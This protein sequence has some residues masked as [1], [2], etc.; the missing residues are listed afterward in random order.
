MENLIS[1][2]EG[3]W[4]K[5]D[6]IYPTEEQKTIL[7][8]NKSE[9]TAQK[10]VISDLI[11]T[12]NTANKVDVDKAIETYNSKK[13]VLEKPEDVYKFIAASFS[14]EGDV[15]SGFINYSLNGVIN[16]INF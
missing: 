3:K 15:V 16:K 2:S 7:N 13:P 8:S 5:K 14:I 6:R 4:M 9:D 1:L 11:R 10:K 12:E